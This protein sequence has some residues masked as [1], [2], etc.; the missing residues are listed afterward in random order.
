MHPFPSLAQLRVLAVAAGS[1]YLK[2]VGL[3]LVSAAF[4]RPAFAEA[5][6]PT[7]LQQ[8]QQCIQKQNLANGINNNNPP[9]PTSPEEQ[10]RSQALAQ[11]CFFSVVMLNPD[12]SVRQDSGDRMASLLQQTG[13]R[14]TRPQ[15]QGQA[16]VA[17]QVQSARSLYKIPVTI[18][19]QRFSFLLDTGASNTVIDHQAA[20]RLK[21]QGKTIPANLL[22]YLAIG[23]QP[24]NQTPLIYAL[25]PILLGQAK[26]T[27]LTGIGLSTRAA[28]FSS[29]GILGL[30][31]LSQF[32]LIISPKS[33]SLTLLRPSAPVA[34]GLPLQGKLGVMT[35]SSILINGKGP[36]TFLLDTGAAVTTLSEGLGRRLGLSLNRVNAV[37][38]IGLS[39]QVAAYWSR[40]SSLT[41]GR[42]Y[43]LTNQAV[44]VANSQVFQTLGVDGVI[45]QDV[46]SKYRQRWRF[47][48]PGPLGTPERGSLELSAR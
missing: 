35:L 18:Q 5:V 15:G 21:L 43:R 14:M 16:Q 26:V 37:D 46:L 38:V 3:T 13:A 12:G 6:S 34:S 4:V 33:R 1:G 47:G 32:D 42:S 39:G 20:R 40:L 8:L 2:F 24:S 19:T 25:P 27:Q 44:L 31:F 9:A 29:D 36:Y 7:L 23:Q 17:L 41:L 48:P 30:D 22:G 10:A 28:P 45:G 11:R